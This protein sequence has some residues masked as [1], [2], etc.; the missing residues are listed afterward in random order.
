MAAV[1]PPKGRLDFEQ[2]LEF[3]PSEVRTKI[4][5]KVTEVATDAFNL[6]TPKGHS[7][8]QKRKC[9]GRIL[10]FSEKP[11]EEPR[12]PSASSASAALF[13]SL[14]PQIS[15][16][17]TISPKTPASASS[18]SALPFLLP[19][20]FSPMSI[21]P[22]TPPSASSAQDFSLFASLGSP[23]SFSPPVPEFDSNESNNAYLSRPLDFDEIDSAQDQILNTSILPPTPGN[24]KKAKPTDLFHGKIDDVIVSPFEKALSDQNFK[25]SKMYKDPLGRSLT[26]VKQV[27]NKN[28]GP[29]CALMLALDK[30]LP[31][32]TLPLSNTFTNWVRQSSLTSGDTLAINLKR[33]GFNPKLFKFIRSSSP[34]EQTSP[35]QTAQLSSEDKI[36]E[37]PFT[38]SHAVLQSIKNIIDKTKNSVIVDI[39]HPDIDGHFIIID[40]VDDKNNNV[41]VRDPYAGEAY[42]V[43]QN[44]LAV[45]LD[46]DGC[47]FYG[48]YLQ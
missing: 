26:V 35:E 24:N 20:M 36:E 9:A 23:T 11:D 30:R 1:K 22:A 34:G 3:L 5:H 41:Y 18:A 13:T 10:D 45:S 40:Y 16:P 8:A 21:S 4:E 14:L 39:S 29:T 43:D 32:E 48:I 42:L 46:N 47:N 44:E 33:E 17:M 7:T 27:S 37:I 6:T 28:C 2:E 15:S 31:Q 19:Q 12:S 25:K 38:D